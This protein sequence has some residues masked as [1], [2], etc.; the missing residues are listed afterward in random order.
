MAYGNQAQE[1]RRNAVLGASPTQLVVMLYD[2]AL[3][4]IEAGRAGMRAGDLSR[5]ND[6]LQRAQ[7]IVSELLATLDREAGGEIADNLA[8]LYDFVLDRLMTANI[9]DAEAP[10]DA[11]TLTLRELRE[12]WV[13]VAAAPAAV[14]RPLM[15]REVALAA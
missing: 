7:R 2:G 11:A 6:G 9:Q 14:A 3:R 13:Q 5:Q 1:Y 12:A 4:F 8:R 15:A 10:L